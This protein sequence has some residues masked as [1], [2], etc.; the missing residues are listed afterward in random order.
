[1]NYSYF[2]VSYLYSLSGNVLK[3]K[4]IANIKHDAIVSSIVLL[5][6]YFLSYS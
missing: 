6:M 3:I 2:S 1:M 4:L 5:N